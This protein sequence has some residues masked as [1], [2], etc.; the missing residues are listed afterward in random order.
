MTNPHY[1]PTGEWESAEGVRER[2]KWESGYPYHPHVQVK[3][4]DVLYRI[5]VLLDK[6]R[7]MMNNK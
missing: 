3:V 1:I 5:G 4:D 2:H 7:A 6:S